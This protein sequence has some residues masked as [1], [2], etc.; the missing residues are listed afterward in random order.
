MGAVRRP[1]LIALVACGLAFSWTMQGTGDNQNAH[2]ALVRALANGTA[3]IDETRGEVGDLSTHDVTLHRGHVYANKAP[4]LAF[5]SL[6]FYLVL[7]AAGVVGE[8]DPTHM[9]WALG[10]VGSVLPAIVLL[11]LVRRASRRIEPGFGT[12]SA[13][14]VG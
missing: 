1:G 9:L 13:V 2:Y 4:G 6:P 7:R 8:G 10:L 5:L 3:T 12:A 11:V 14:V